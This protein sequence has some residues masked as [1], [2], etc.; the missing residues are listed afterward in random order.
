MKESFGVVAK[1]KKPTFEGADA[2]PSEIDFR[3]RDLCNIADLANHDVFDKCTKFDSSMFEVRTF[4]NKGLINKGNNIE[5]GELKMCVPS[6]GY[7]VCDEDA[8]PSWYCVNLDDNSLAPQGNKG[9]PAYHVQRND[10]KVQCNV[11]VE[12]CETKVVVGSSSHKV[13]VP[14]ITNHKLIK[15]GAEVVVFDS[16]KKPKK[17]E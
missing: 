14:Y 10:E 2:N 7:R 17:G 4:P 15:R 11:S 5:K 1:I 9:H 6:L 13:M 3:T 8:T 16:S 12:Y